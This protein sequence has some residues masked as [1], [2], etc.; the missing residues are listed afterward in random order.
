MNLRSP[1]KPRNH[2]ELKIVFRRSKDADLLAEPPRIKNP[3]TS[4][5]YEMSE[6]FQAFLWS[7]YMRFLSQPKK[8]KKIS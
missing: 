4:G 1:P 5:K 7:M 8:G 3:S 6:P 2:H